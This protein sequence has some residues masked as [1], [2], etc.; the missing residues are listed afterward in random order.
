MNNF[1]TAYKDVAFII[2]LQAIDAYKNMMPLLRKYKCATQQK[3]HSYSQAG[4]TKK[5]PI[6][7]CAGHNIYI[8]SIK[9]SVLWM[10]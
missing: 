7:I 8:K 5:I 2:N 1:I 6:T 9:N 10:F 4:L 3:Q